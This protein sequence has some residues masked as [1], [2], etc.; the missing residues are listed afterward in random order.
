MID[1]VSEDGRRLISRRKALSILGGLGLGS[2]LAAACGSGTGSAR[3]SSTTSSPPSSA[4]CVLAPEMTEGPYYLNLKLVRRDITEGRPGAPLVLAFTVV[5]ARCSPL[6]DA[7]V[8]IW[9]ADALGTYSGVGSSPD[10]TFLRGTQLTDANGRCQFATIYPGWYMGRAVHIHLK[11]H[12]GS[13]VVHTGQLFF[14]DTFSDARYRS[15]PYSSRGAPDTRNAAD[16]IYANG[17][18]VSTLSPQ[19]SGSGYAA[20]TTLAVTTT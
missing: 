1:M 12:V 4:R 2:A 20:A 19:A 8:D 3:G 17:G 11:V 7:A 6:R 16:S 9:H 18:A 10:T 13:N 14:P 5:D 15:S